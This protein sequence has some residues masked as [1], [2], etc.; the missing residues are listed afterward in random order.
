MKQTVIYHANCNDGFCA[1]WLMWKRWP[2]FDYIPM[3]YGSPLPEGLEKHVTFVDF[4]LKL[5]PM[6]DLVSKGHVVT[7]LDHHATAAEEL[8]DLLHPNFKFIYDV[9]KC[10]ARIVKDYFSLPNHWIIDMVEDRDLWRFRLHGTREI[11][12]AI[13][14]HEYS[15]EVW[16][17]FNRDT[18]YH[19]G[20]VLLGHKKRRVDYLA[21]RAF[22]IDLDGTIVPCVNCTEK[23]LVSDLGH[24]L[25]IKHESGIGCVFTCHNDG[26]NFSIRGNG[27]VNVAEIAKRYGGGGHYSAA[28]FKLDQFPRTV[29]VST[30][31]AHPS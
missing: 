26:Y 9:N 20:S 1:A 22:E 6:M 14:V 4:S 18:M 29:Q 24:M 10:G 15:F 30:A 11:H 7:V 25:A 27:N 16:D 8:D 2:Q 21:G 5:E 19:L 3:G 28:G 31:G 13:C 23:N 12:E 17:Q